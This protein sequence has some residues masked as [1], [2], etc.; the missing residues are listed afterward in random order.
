MTSSPDLIHELRESRPTAPAELRDRVREITAE[1][2]TTAPWQR[3][4]FPVR[5]S[6]LVAVPAAAALAFA[7]AGILGFARSGVSSHRVAGENAPTPVLV[8]KQLIPAGTPGSLI[9]SQ[10]L[11]A[12]TTRPAKEVEV[13][14]IVDPSYLSGLV[15]AADIFPGQE[16][17]STSFAAPDTT[18]TLDQS[19]QAGDRAQRVS[20]TLTV[21]VDDADAVSS[22]AQDALDLTRSLGGFVVSSSVSTGEEG[23]AAITVR[24]PVDR[25]QEAIT[26]LSGLGRIVTQQV[27]VDDLQ[28]SLDELEQREAK[29]RSEIARIRARLRTETL[30][31]QTEAV[32]RARLQTLRTE[33]TG[34]RTSIASTQSEASM[35]TIQLTVVT[36]GALGAVAP[37]SRIERTLD[38]ALNILAWEAVIALGMLIVLAPFALVGVAAWL[39]RRLYR[40]HEEERLLA[41]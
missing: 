38:E 36:P 9:A 19:A 25:V 2:P 7:S 15:T 24:I 18:T 6:V 40:R 27:T 30:D 39:A 16:I 37:P 32:L 14:A 29:V 20:A 12:A 5:R 3:W 22:A 11:Y 10:E 26:G 1:R 4:R 13:G 28:Q 21:E 17:T 35:S 8:A 41:A 31:A 34:L 33:L 23:S